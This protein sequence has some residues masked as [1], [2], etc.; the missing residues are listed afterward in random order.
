MEIHS[1]QA[2]RYSR[3]LKHHID[4]VIFLSAQGLAIRG[5]DESIVSSNRGNFIELL[6]LLGNYSNDFKAFLHKERA[7][8]TSHGPQNEL[9]ECLYHEVRDEIQ[10][11]YRVSSVDHIKPYPLINPACIK[12]STVE[13]CFQMSLINP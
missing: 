5:H 9:I 6:G 3:M 7:T 10:H 4:A 1:K 8:Y 11:P 13:Y 2:S 12:L